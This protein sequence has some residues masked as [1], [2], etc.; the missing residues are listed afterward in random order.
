MFRDRR[1]PAYPFRFKDWSDFQ[2]VDVEIGTGDGTLDFFQLVKSYDLIFVV[3]RTIQ[4]P[5]EGTVE[6][7]VDGVLKT[8]TTHYA[9]DYSTGAIIFTSG[10]IPAAGKVVTASF[11]FD[12][13]VRFADDALK[14][15][16]T[17]DDFGDIPSI[18][19][20]EVLNE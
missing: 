9:V 11:E 17:M 12:V 5:V 8:E 10:N 6:I 20:I 15:S 3:T 14:V 4:L 18:T 13:P 1:G 19:L 2:A 7:S 16:M